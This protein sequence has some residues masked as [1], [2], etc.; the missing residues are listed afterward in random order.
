VSKDPVKASSVGQTI[1]FLTGDKRSNRYSNLL[2]DAQIPSPIGYIEVI[3]S[4]QLGL[5]MGIVVYA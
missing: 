2:A 4:H 1:D 3:K 5:L